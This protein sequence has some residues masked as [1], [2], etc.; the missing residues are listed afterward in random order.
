MRIR[1]SA[2]IRSSHSRR[3]RRRACFFDGG[4]D[5][6]RKL[7]IAPLKELPDILFD[8]ADLLVR[9][10]IC[11]AL[12]ALDLPALYL[13]LAVFIDAY[14]NC[15]EDY[16]FLT[17]PERF[18]CWDRE[19]SDFEDEPVELGGFRL[20][21]V[22]TYALDAAVLDNIPLNQRLLFKMGGVLGAYI[23]CHQDIAAIF[24]GDGESGAR[25]VSIPDY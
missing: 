11:E 13:H 7:G 6:A 21:G 17:F 12:V 3:D 5:Y 23:V 22:Y 19:K 16:W 8:G 9:S 18:D 14:K 24:R 20:Y 4:A 10:H 15:H 25:L 1:W 2:T